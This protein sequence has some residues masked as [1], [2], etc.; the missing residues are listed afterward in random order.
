MQL[1][2]DPA[3]LSLINVAAGELLSR[4]GQPAVPIHRDDGLGNVSVVVA[5]PPGAT[6]VSGSGVVCVLSFQAKASG[7]TALT[8]T[9]AGVV[10]SAQQQV[11]A[12]TGHL[13]LVVK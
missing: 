4:D 5:R 13:D 6:G 10:N 9:R 1:Q 3:R 8:M 11:Q 7:A 2:Y 12:T